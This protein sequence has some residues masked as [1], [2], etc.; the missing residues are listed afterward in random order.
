MR[1]GHY[2]F[3]VYSRGGVCRGRRDQVRTVQDGMPSIG[4][5]IQWDQTMGPSSTNSMKCRPVGLSPS[6]PRLEECHRRK[7]KRPLA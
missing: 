5:C 3:V 1:G 4:Q 2:H 7:G 6:L